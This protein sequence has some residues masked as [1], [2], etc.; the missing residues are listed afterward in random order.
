MKRQIFI[1]FLFLSFTVFA[2][3][4]TISEYIKTTTDDYRLKSKKELADTFGKSRNT[5][6]LKGVELRTETKNFDILKQK[7]SL[8][9][10]FKSIGETKSSNLMLKSY[11]DLYNAEYQIDFIDIL[12]E[13][14]SLVL[15]NIQIK[16]N[17]EFL[18]SM[19]AVLED[20][21]A[22]LR[23]MGSI[24]E[25]TNL[26]EIVDTEEKLTDIELEKIELE[27][28]LS[29]IEI[30]ITEQTESEKKVDFTNEKLITIDEIEKRIESME[31][32]GSDLGIL[33]E[34]RKQRVALAESEL[35]NEKAK[36]YDF[37]NYLA[38]DYDTDDWEVPRNSFSIGISV[39]LPGIKNDEVDITRK[40]ADVIE[41]KLKCE[42]EKKENE[43][44]IQNNIRSIKRQI[45]QYRVILEK[46][47]DSEAVTSLSKYTSIE[48]ADPLTILKIKERVIKDEM[49]MQSILFKIY[50]RYITLLNLTGVLPENPDENHISGN[51]AQ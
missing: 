7:Y 27:N 14:Y 16:K 47:M 26:T 15:E 19:S 11:K 18:D 33:F 51:S 23:K 4:L 2:T 30:I 34:Y 25:S 8:R 41:E 10:H 13:R 17:L 24:S 42:M 50:V 20:K 43:K 35:K 6:L 22:V 49:K 37:F 38:L 40:K 32:N 46:N 48:G 9:F 36:T 39:N 12:L 31:K 45:K 1:L 29:A 44:S 21:I 28:R 3:D 5:P